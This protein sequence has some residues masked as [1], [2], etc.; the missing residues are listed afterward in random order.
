MRPRQRRGLLTHIRDTLRLR[1]P[2]AITPRTHVRRSA[3]RRMQRMTWLHMT[4]RRIELTWRGG[5]HGQR[6]PPTPVTRC[7]IRPVPPTQGRAG[8]QR[9]LHTLRL[10]ATR[11]TRRT[12]PG[13]IRRTRRTRLRGIRR[14]QRMLQLR[15]TRHMQRTQRLHVTRRTQRMLRLRRTP[16]T[17]AM[18]PRR[19][20]VPPGMS[21]CRACRTA[22]GCSRSG[23]GGR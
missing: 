6:T 11:R 4:T 10:R 7:R 12:R 23:A 3:T 16:C 20:P 5:L 15:A 8:I 17:P 1:E 18:L 19:L 13:G 9:T 14:T 2:P 21:R 22:C